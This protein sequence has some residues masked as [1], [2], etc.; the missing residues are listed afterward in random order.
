MLKLM[1]FPPA[2]SIL[3]LTAAA[4]LAQDTKFSG[5]WL[6]NPAQ[7]TIR[8][9]PVLPEQSLRV[10]QTESGFTAGE[11]VYLFNGKSQKSTVR[12]S[13]WTIATKWEGSAL[14]ANITVSGPQNYSMNERW[15]KSRDSHTLTITRTIVLAGS[16]SESVLV[17]GAGALPV[18]QSEAPV[19]PAEVTASYKVA[20]GTRILLRLTNSLNTKHSS[21]GDKVYLQTAS[22]VFIDRKLIIPVGSYINGSV[23]ESTRAGRVK[24]KAGL[25]VRFESLILPNG[26]KRDFISRPGSVDGRGNLDRTEGRISGDSN[27]GGDAKTVGQTASAAAGIGSIAGAVAGH[28]GAGLGIGAAAGAAAGLAGVLASRGPDVTLASGTTMELVLDRD[29]VFSAEELERLQ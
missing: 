8:N 5:E 4:A 10:D 1:R 7:S 9:L 19:S 20:A 11:A 24:G 18:L 28:T 16:E 14:L 17:Y 23:V 21:V 3:F 2:L 25:N 29:M 15:A 26:T 22:P 12:D 6:L 27:K 13:V